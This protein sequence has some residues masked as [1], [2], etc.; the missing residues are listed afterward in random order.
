MDSE[1]IK[2]NFDQQRDTLIGIITTGL[3]CVDD[4]EALQKLNNQITELWEIWD[5]KVKHL[6]SEQ[7]ERQIFIL[8]VV[9]H[10]ILKYLD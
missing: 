2:M 5:C 7:E 10:E 6:L 4:K 8:S 3:Y 9:L 1:V